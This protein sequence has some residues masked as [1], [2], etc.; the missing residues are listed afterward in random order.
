MQMNTTYSSIQHNNPSLPLP[1]VS[2]INK[3]ECY[4]R[5]HPS[6]YLLSYIDFEANIAVLASSFTM[7]GSKLGIPPCLKKLGSAT[8]KPRVE[9]SMVCTRTARRLNS[10]DLAASKF[11]YF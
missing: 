2:R 3:Y 5:V 10:L 7:G 6:I 1:N 8:T 4:I 11:E 9:I